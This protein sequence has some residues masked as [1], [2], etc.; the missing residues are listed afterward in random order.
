MKGSE[1]NLS[2]SIDLRSEY[3]PYQSISSCPILHL[4]QRASLKSQREAYPHRINSLL[5][6]RNQHWW[7]KP[8]TTTSSQ[9]SHLACRVLEQVLITA[10][11]THAR[12]SDIFGCQPSTAINGLR[13]SQSFIRHNSFPFR[14]SLFL[15]AK[16]VAKS[17]KIPI[18]PGDTSSVSWKSKHT[19]TLIRDCLWPH[20]DT[21]MSG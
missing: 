9:F 14:H 16:S 6:K 17:A 8:R 13:E 11:G 4:N 2:T 7:L 5:W 18:N 12:P 1:Q 19:T 3:W 21:T 15:V 20:D 10:P